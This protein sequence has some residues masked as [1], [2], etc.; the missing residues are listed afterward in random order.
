MAKYRK[1]N[2]F[3]IGVY[4]AD[5][6]FIPPQ[7]KELLERCDVVIYDEGAPLEL[8]ITLP[9]DTEKQY[10]G[11]KEDRPLLAGDKVNELILGF[12]EQG[13]TV[14]RL[15]DNDS[16]M[17]GCGREA[18]NFLK[19]QGI[20]PEMIT[21]TTPTG[22]EIVSH[23]NPSADLPLTGL[24]IM[25]TRPADQSHDL[26][27]ALRELGAEPLPYPTIATQA[28]T[29]DHAWKKIQENDNPDS[30]LVFTSENGVRYFIQQFDKR[31]GK[32][33]RLRK[34]NIAV[35]GAGTQRALADYGLTADFIPSRATVDDLAAEM[36]KTVDLR[37]ATTVRV[38]GDLADGGIEDRL[39]SCGATVI[40]ITVYRT[41]HPGWPPGFKERLIER[42]PDAILFTS[43]SSVKGLWHNL[44]SAEVKK[45][46][47]HTRIFSLGPMVTRAMEQL[48]LEATR[49]AGEFTIP[50]LIETLIDYYKR[51]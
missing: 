30:W 40:P 49:Q 7:G 32:I 19:E 42:P 38:R 50:G 4:S 37:G 6:A 20:D 1:G 3:L 15:I 9:S 43:A 31:I 46:V 51:K 29:D 28:V 35:V 16:L 8:I 13:K 39:S 25:V 47:L 24:R 45:L 11:K 44:A 27:Q 12:A 23:R 18:V 34:Y 22:A 48:G 14:A 33:G 17:S 5:P 36:A 10:I 26:Y 41:I 2:V 21:A